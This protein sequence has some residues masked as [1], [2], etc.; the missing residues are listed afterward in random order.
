MSTDSPL[1]TP[2]TGLSNKQNALEMQ[3]TPPQHDLGGFMVRRAL[4]VAQRRLVGPWIFFD[5]FGPVTFPPGQ[6]IDVR[7]HPHINL[8]TVTYLFAGEMLHRDSLGNEVA[9][10]PGE[11]NLMVAGKGIVHSERQ[12]DEIKA[13]NNHLEGLQ[14]WLALPEA[15][16]EINPNFYHYAPQQIPE[17]DVN[18]VPVR[19]LIG[20]AYGLTSPVKTFANTLYIEARLRQGQQLALPDGVTERG[21]YVVKG[22]LKL[23]DEL[24]HEHNM[25][26]IRPGHSV[27]VNAEQDST[28]VVVGGSK[29]SKRYIWWNFVSSQKQRIEQA[30]Q[31][32]RNGEF[33]KVPGDEIEFIPL[34]DEEQG[35]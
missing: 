27:T 19:V 30:K 1:K 22:Q 32:W 29:L 8:A 4:P 26:I 35:Q 33:P 31:K 25:A 9:I 5:H 24:I 18:D 17:T 13:R 10:Q 2:Q 23:Q 20:N 11:I 21:V 34:P 12:R 7:P 16:E 6:G 14:L 15:D 28:L 3:I